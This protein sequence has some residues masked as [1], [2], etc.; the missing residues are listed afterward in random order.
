MHQAAWPWIRFTTETLR[1]WK[2]IYKKVYKL[3]SCK[4]R[5]ENKDRDE[6]VEIVA[7]QAF[8]RKTRAMKEQTMTRKKKKHTRKQKHSK[9]AILSVDWH[10]ILEQ[11]RPMP[12]KL[13]L[14]GQHSL[15]TSI[16]MGTLTR[17]NPRNSLVLTICSV[18]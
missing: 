12:S 15:I 10:W 1:L 14:A 5:K 4:I 18:Y 8:K 6:I 11:Y 7:A 9:T 13:R 17:L 3:K 16:L 2:Q